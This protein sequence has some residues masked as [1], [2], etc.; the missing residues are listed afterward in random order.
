[1]ALVGA[2]LLVPAFAAGVE[3]PAALSAV[4]DNARCPAGLAIDGFEKC[5]AWVSLHGSAAGPD[6]PGDVTVGP[7]GTAYTIGL[8]DDGGQ[9]DAQVVAIDPA[10]GLERWSAVVGMPD[11]LDGAS[12][13]IVRGGRLYIAGTML[14]TGEGL[15]YEMHAFDAASGAVLW[16]ATYARPGHNMDM[17]SDIAASADGSL[18]FVTGTSV[19]DS[20]DVGTIALDGAT[21][22]LVW[23]ARFDGAGAAEDTGHGLALSPDGA[24]LY[25]AGSTVPATTR[26]SD[27]LLL[28]YDTAS[29]DLAWSA[30]YDGPD[31]GGEDLFAVA[32]TSDGVYATG[33]SFRAP[34]GLAGI[35]LG[36]EA[37]TGA[38][39]WSDRYAFAEE[40]SSGG[41]AIAAS[42]DGT[43]VT[44]TGS[45]DHGFD[46]GDEMR[47]YLTIT[48]DTASG[49]PLW[50]D[51]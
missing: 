29:G 34:F 36:F 35:T 44:M 27:A 39:R 38:A 21:G 31:H 22:A 49:S 14:A 16:S 23:V 51:R 45:S 25:V 43:R 11:L 5:E 41:N 33:Y 46:F 2:L 10:S 1:V 37:D 3:P 47:D 12:V 30:T 24:R 4:V 48:Y 28:A 13:G 18:V 32:A 20:S 9:T 15:D 7:D 50:L 26:H 17:V 6:D 40:T 8:S 19:G 42:P